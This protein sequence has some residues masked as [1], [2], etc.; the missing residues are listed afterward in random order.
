MQWK[1]FVLLEAAQLVG[2]SKQA[3]FVTPERL[4]AARLA[5]LVNLQSV[6][7]WRMLFL[8]RLEPGKRCSQL[9]NYA[10]KSKG[11]PC[12]VPS[13]KTAYKSCQVKVAKRCAL[14]LGQWARDIKQD[15][16]ELASDH[17]VCESQLSAC[18]AE[19]ALF[20]SVS[21]LMKTMQTNTS[22]RFQNLLLLMQFWENNLHS[23][24]RFVSV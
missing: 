19:A 4:T 6:N 12:F 2:E 10:M 16:R 21:L 7:L 15:D 18:N 17:V 8:A 22:A 1:Y 20:L 14:R 9:N 3:K 11:W 23:G 13:W 24:D 5:V